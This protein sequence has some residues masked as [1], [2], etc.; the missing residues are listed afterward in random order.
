VKAHA[1]RNVSLIACGQTANGFTAAISQLACG[2]VDGLGPGDACGR[3][4]NITGNRD[5]FSPEN[6][7]Q[8]TSIIVKI[9][10]MCPIQDNLFWC[11]Q[12]RSN[13]VNSLNKAVQCV[14][15]FSFSSLGMSD[16]LKEWQF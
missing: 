2:S 11:G 8:P 15:H 9:T 16:M 12:T 3:C 14:I 13:P 4:F 6:P 5:P 7:I 10:D 1:K